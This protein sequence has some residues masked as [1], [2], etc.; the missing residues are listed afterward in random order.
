ML[1]RVKIIGYVMV[2]W[3]LTGCVG[4]H[5]VIFQKPYRNT[6]LNCLANFTFYAVKTT[7]IKTTLSQDTIVLS[8]GGAKPFRPDSIIE[9]KYNAHEMLITDF[10]IDKV[11]IDTLYG[12]SRTSYQYFT[13][14]YHSA[15]AVNET[16]PSITLGPVTCS[17]VRGAL[18]EMD[19]SCIAT[20]ASFTYHI[21]N[22]TPTNTQPKTIWLIRVK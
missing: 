13:V 20:Q 22:P 7:D 4:K 15:L 16:I 5:G 21:V 1:T 19:E 17:N 14:E 11:I 18:Q 10:P 12:Q 9:F 6:L 2:L 3:A 8:M